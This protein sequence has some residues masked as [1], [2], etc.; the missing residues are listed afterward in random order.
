MCAGARSPSATNGAAAL[1]NHVFTMVVHDVDR[2][3]ITAKGIRLLLI[4][5]V[6]SQAVLHE[7]PPLTFSPAA[8]TASAHH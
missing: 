1:T 6:A 4:A 5:L 3:S 8:W 2:R 7:R